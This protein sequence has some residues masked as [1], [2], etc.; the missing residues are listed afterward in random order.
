[1]AL[2]EFEIGKIAEIVAG[3][4]GAQLDAKTLRRVI[5]RVTDALK[6]APANPSIEGVTCE[7]PRSQPAPEG[8]SSP[9]QQTRSESAQSRQPLPPD[10]AMIADRGGLYE[11]IEKSEGNRVIIAAFGKD[12]PGIV[13][14]LTGVLA[15]HNVSIEDISQTLMQ[16]YF[17]M[18]LIA[19][20]SGANLDFAALRDRLQATEGRLGM[21]VYVVH[22]DTFGYMHRI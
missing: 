16:E 13:A 22:E 1:M 8:P 18:I 2:S 10:E 4:T 12:R 20:I 7:V 3:R 5:D 15:E 21:K 14:A 17:S 11:Q 9:I 19:N 6:E